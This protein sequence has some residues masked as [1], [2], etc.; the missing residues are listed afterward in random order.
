MGEPAVE[1]ALAAIGELMRQAHRGY[2]SIGL[3][4]DELDVMLKEL[5]A[6]GPRKGVYGARVSGGGSGGTVVVLCREDAIPELEALA[7]R[8]TFGKPFAGLI[9]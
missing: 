2:T 6:L 8:L 4:C 7:R 9:R 5:S 1:A 3:G